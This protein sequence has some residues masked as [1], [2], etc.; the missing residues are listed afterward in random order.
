MLLGRFAR[1]SVQFVIE[2]DINLMMQQQL[3]QQQQVVYAASYSLLRPKKVDD[4]FE[5]SIRFA[6][7]ESRFVLGVSL[8]G[9]WTNS[10]FKFVSLA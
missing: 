3:Q 10:N 4:E 7:C 9:N 8:A 1:R 5:V 6:A 2:L